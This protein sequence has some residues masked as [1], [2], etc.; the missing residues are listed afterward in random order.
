M[1]T[2]LNKADPAVHQS[3]LCESFTSKCDYNLW[4]T[5]LRRISILLIVLFDESALFLVISQQQPRASMPPPNK[6]WINNLCHNQHFSSFRFNSKYCENT[7][8][9]TWWLNDRIVYSYT[10][11]VCKIREKLGKEWM[12]W[13]LYQSFLLIYISWVYWT[14]SPESSIFNWLYCYTLTQDVSFE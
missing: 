1:W 3:K 10:A 2:K 4:A 13:R 12:I 8:S 6:L 11:G 5:K 9:W 14:V 7:E